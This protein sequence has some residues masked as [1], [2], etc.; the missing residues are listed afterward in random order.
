MQNCASIVGQANRA[1]VTA[2]L[3]NGPKLT[4][5]KEQ[6]GN[7]PCAPSC[8]F[9]ITAA[10]TGNK[11]IPGPIRLIDFVPAVFDPVIDGVIPGG[12]K[13]DCQKFSVAAV[14]CQIPGGLAP[15][16]TGAIRPDLTNGRR[17]LGGQQLCLA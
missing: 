17:R 2:Q 16:P 9:R 4:L 10:N 3:F 15:G 6:V 1:C 14:T 12:P 7:G 13:V 8:T 5:K 11:P